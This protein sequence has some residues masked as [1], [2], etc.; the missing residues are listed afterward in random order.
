M[1]LPELLGLAA[2]VIAIIGSAIYLRSR[3]GSDN[4]RSSQDTAYADADW[5][6]VGAFARPPCRLR[7]VHIAR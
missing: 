4:R 7:T 6:E 3:M 5:P 1:E 2:A